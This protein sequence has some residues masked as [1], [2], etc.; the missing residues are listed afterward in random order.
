MKFRTST[1]IM[2]ASWFAILVLYILVRPNGST[3]LPLKMIPLLTETQEPVP[4]TTD[5]PS[6]ETVS[7]SS[8]TSPTTVSESGTTTPTTTE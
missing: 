2:V 8:T 4:T 5:P 3:G 6:S 1:L 7:P